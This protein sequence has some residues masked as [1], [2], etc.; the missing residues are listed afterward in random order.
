MSD[1]LPE[2]MACVEIS[3]GNLINATRPVPQPG[4]D[5]VLVRVAAAGVNRPDVLQRKGGYP[6]PP[7]ASDIPGLEIAGHVVAL[8]DGVTSLSIDDAVMALVTGGG[9]AEYCT[10]PVAQCLPVPKGLEM[11]E[12]AA[13][14]ETFFTVWSNVFE[15]AGLKPG[16]TFL[17]HGGSSG[18]GTTAIQLA[19]ALGSTVI[20][21]AGNDEKCGACDVLGADLAINYREQDFVEAVKEFTDGK[22]VDVI[23]D[24][25]GG[26]YVGRNL[27]ALAVDGRLVNIAFLNG[28]K[29]EVDMMPVML[30][31]LTLSGSTLRARSVEFKAAIAAQLQ[32][33]I[34]PLVETG[35]I[36]P[37]IHATFSLNE[38]A[39]AHELMESSQHIGKIVLVS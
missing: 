22:G 30:K 32:A 10:A 23:L 5:E 1:K 6:P 18:I 16:E 26:D 17:V 24:M 20:T 19:H 11:D 14:P 33:R 21:T 2:T 39:A 31:R 29:V 37:F 3:N 27:K 35:E 9:Y 25:V 36:A 12:A 8:G 4:V 38:A 28:S 34:W 13:M 15:R 7:G